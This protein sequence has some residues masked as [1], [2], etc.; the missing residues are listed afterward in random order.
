[1]YKKSIDFILNKFELIRYRKECLLNH[2][3]VVFV[4]GVYD[5]LHLGHLRSLEFAKS[6][7]D[8]LIVG[9]NDDV[10]AK[11]K[12]KNR[13]IQ[14]EDERAALVAGLEC[15][16]R[17]Y[18]FSEKNIDV[19]RLLRPDSYILSTTSL[20]KP[21]DR[22]DEIEFVEKSGGK[23]IITKSFYNSHTTKIIEKIY[24]DCGKNK[25]IGLPI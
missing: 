20:K 17:V 25:I 10:F 2:K 8:I 6:L 23:V 24:D 13:P 15:V 3:K 9:I 11:N 16:D 21:K 4:T 19:L 1:M 5:I 18:V 7:G 14:K 12:G 22:M